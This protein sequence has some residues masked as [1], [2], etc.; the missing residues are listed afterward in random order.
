MKNEPR[1]FM[2]LIGFI[3]N[4]LFIFEWTVY[5]IN[6]QMIDSTQDLFILSLV[7]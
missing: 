4:T 1:L 7:L 3:Q 5:A 6:L 2:L